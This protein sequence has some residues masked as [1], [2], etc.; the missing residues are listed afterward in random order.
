LKKLPLAAVANESKKMGAF[1]AAKK[2]EGN[3]SPEKLK[4]TVRSA[5]KPLKPIRWRKEQ[6]PVILDTS[7]GPISK[8]GR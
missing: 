1:S 7:K 2:D 4:T 6:R 8:L 5:G 3:W